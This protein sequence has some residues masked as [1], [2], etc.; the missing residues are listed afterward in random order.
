MNKRLLPFS[1]ALLF[2][3]CTFAG[4]DYRL[5]YFYDVSKYV[6]DYA[7]V[8]YNFSQESVSFQVRDDNG[9]FF[10]PLGEKERADFVYMFHEGGTTDQEK[11]AFLN[12]LIKTV[13]QD[14]V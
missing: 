9:I 8:T 10:F 14:L 1:I 5:N 13:L 2:A 4:S 7:R 3:L 11:T 6:K 12:R